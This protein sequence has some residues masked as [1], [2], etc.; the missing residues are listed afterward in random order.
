MAI[1]MIPDGKTIL[2]GIYLISLP[3][4]LPIGPVNVVL[5]EG[6]P[7]TLIDCGPNT[8]ET[9]GFLDKALLSR[10]LTVEDIRILI[11]THCHV[12]HFGLAGWIK[13]R[14]GATIMAHPSSGS[15]KFGSNLEIR[16][17]FTELFLHRS[18]V[19]EEEIAKVREVSRHLRSLELP[20]RVDEPLEDREGLILGGRDWRVL[21]TPGHTT[22]CICLESPRDKLMISG[23]HLIGH[24]SSNAILEPETLGSLRPA[25]NLPTY[26]KTLRRTAKLDLELV[27]PGH[28][29]IITN[30]RALISARLEMHE[31]RKSQLVAF[32]KDRPLTAYEICNLMFPGVENEHIYLGVSEVIGHL[33]LLEDDG[34]IEMSHKSGV[35]WYQFKGVAEGLRG[36]EPAPM[37]GEID[38]R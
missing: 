4:S 31:Q 13:E 19:P 1:E 17:E 8:E 7:L 20:M 33:Q 12:D 35:D 5:L 18:G 15:A 6:D 11:L 9:R 28:G 27:I 30:H 36:K 24:I 23:D 26:L 22:G 3:T 34:A 37:E 32:I 2:D 10:G 14:S 21:E 16:H 38:A 25:R 29:E